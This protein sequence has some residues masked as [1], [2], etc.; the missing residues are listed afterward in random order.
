MISVNT[1]RV[2]CLRDNEVGSDADSRN[3]PRLRG[4]TGCGS[5]SSASSGGS[6]MIVDSNITSPLVTGG[7]GCCRCGLCMRR[8][9][10]G[11]G[12]DGRWGGTRCSTEDGVTLESRDNPH[13]RKRINE[14]MLL[15]YKRL[16]RSWAI[17]TRSRLP[18]N[19]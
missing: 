16:C 14:P 13:G 12:G 4:R 3:N 19:D 9:Q 5:S 1:C 11:R 2:C 15:R 7:T 6:P 10:K 8:C 17:N 18:R